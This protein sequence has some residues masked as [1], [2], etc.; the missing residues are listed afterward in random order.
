MSFRVRVRPAVQKDLHTLVDFS[1]AMA[2]ETESLTLDRRRLRRG[3]AAILSTPA[4]GFLRVAELATGRSA[5]IVG[6]MMVTYEWSDWRNATFW[7]IQSVYVDPTW[8]RHGVYRTMHEALRR[9]ARAT[10]GVCGLRLYVAR[11]NRAAQRTYREMGMITARYRVFEDDFIIRP[12][13]PR[14]TGLRNPP[15]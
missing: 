12:I 7:W 2:S 10:P 8:R 13:S 15:A 5:R 3:L 4:L 9:E 1:R 6:Q 11:D 14:R